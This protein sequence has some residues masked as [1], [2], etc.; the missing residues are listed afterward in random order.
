[1]LTDRY[2]RPIDYLRISVT[3]RCNLRCEYCNPVNR[4]R[5]LEAGAILSFEEIFQVASTAV[6]M[7]V[8]KLRITGGEP[9]VRRG[10]LELVAMLSRLDGVEELAMT[11]NAV[12]LPRYAQPL[13]DAGL[14]R[15][16]ISLDTL[17]PVRFAALTGGGD[18]NKVIAGIEAAVTAG[19]NPVKL[20]C[21][22]NESPDEEDARMVQ[23]FAVQRGLEARFIRRMDINSGRFWVVDGG[24]G[25]DCS[26]C[27]RLRLTSDGRLKPCLF[28]DVSFNV[29]ELGAREA[30]LAA[31]AAKP[32]CGGAAQD[33]SFQT[34]GG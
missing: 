2:D 5:L 34:I 14:H 30:V 24:T 13:R 7:G 18:V 22:I 23:Q 10:V 29:R 8:R 4:M 11:S 17:D 31:V 21:V 27:N 32:R 3:D 6:E 28:N 19:L 16:N 33:G 25:G 9:L 15:V 1:M 12:L 26:R 20:N